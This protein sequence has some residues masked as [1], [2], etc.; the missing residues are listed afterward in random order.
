[1]SPMTI[2]KRRTHCRSSVRHRQGFALAELLIVIA[3]LG[4]LAAIAVPQ[5]NWSK[6]KAHDAVVV[7]DMRRAMTSFEEYFVLHNAYP[8]SMEAA[9]FQPSLKVAFTA[10]ELVDGGQAIHVDA[11]HVNS[12]NFFHLKYP[13]DNEPS[14]SKKGT[15]DED[16]VVAI[17]DP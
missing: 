6:E 7:S 8:P 9:G 16:N 5:Y 13:E 12:G 4:L 14:R 3:L 1:M 15:A 11:E 10:W 17:P 2:G